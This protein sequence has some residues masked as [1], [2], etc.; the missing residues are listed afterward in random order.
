M[1][2]GAQHGSLEALHTSVLNASLRL[3]RIESKQVGLQS[4]GAELKPDICAQTPADISCITVDEQMD[5]ESC[6]DLKDAER[7]TVQP[8]DRQTLFC[9]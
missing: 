3:V 5:D 8:V 1:A 6:K 2:W 9:S 7:Q 4:G